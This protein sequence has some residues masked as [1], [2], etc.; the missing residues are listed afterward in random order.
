MSGFEI[1]GLV[2]GIIPL[3]KL[4]FDATK[5]L[6]KRFEDFH[7]STR[8]IAT[9]ENNVEKIAHALKQLYSQYGN[10]QRSISG[11]NASIIETDFNY[12]A[13]TFHQVEERFTNISQPDQSRPSRRI[14]PKL[15]SGLTLIISNRRPSSCDEIITELDNASQ[16]LSQINQT[17]ITVN[18]TYGIS[19][20]Q[21]DIILQLQLLSKAIDNTSEGQDTYKPSF[22]VP[23]NPPLAKKLLDYAAVDN[24]GKALTPEGKL[25]AD[26]L[27]LINKL[28]ENHDTLPVVGC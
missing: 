2:S 13:S 20:T 6:K 27:N 26:L 1:A 9:I 10:H 19:E 11:Q 5:T 15:F 24:K 8:K 23:T 3:L 22:Y 28:Q 12:R 7:L 18:T 21:D 16:R 4:A 17:L 25:K 14:F